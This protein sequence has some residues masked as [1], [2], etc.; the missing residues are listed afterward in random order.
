VEKSTET[1]FEDQNVDAPGLLLALLFEKS[2][3]ERER[4]TFHSVRVKQ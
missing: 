2:N 4:E 3:G 1:G